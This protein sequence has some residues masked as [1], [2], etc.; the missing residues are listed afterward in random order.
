M[1]ASPDSIWKVL[2]NEPPPTLVDDI[3]ETAG[4]ITIRR[5]RFASG[6]PGSTDAIAHAVIAAPLI[7]HLHPGILVLHGG[8]G[9]A[10]VDRAIAWARRGYVA[11]A[12]DLPGIADA[13]KT[14]YSSGAWRSKPYGGEFWLAEP[15]AS[16]SSI[17]GAV[18]TA[19]RAFRLLQHH[20][21]ADPARLGVIGNSWGGFT[22][23]LLSSLL[24]TEVAAGFSLFGCGSYEETVFAQDLRRITHEHSR[25]WIALL[26][27]LPW[28]S[29]I[30]APFFLAAASNDSFFWPPAVLSTF[31]ALPS[32][33]SLMVA[34]N[35]NHE[36]AFAGGSTSGS[37]FWTA[38]EALFFDLHLRG[39]GLPF[40]RIRVAEDHDGRV[41]LETSGPLPLRDVRLYVS[42]RGEPWATRIW[43]EMPIENCGGGR[44]LA[45][46]RGI[47]ATDWFATATDQRPVS[48]STPVFTW[49]P[50]S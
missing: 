38:Q 3:T 30:R 17:F 7:P 6:W 15:D 1:N 27:P 14:E 26:D 29:R 16:H 21:N 20:S 34:P 10:E 11:I 19:I 40:P 5:V 36:A 28:V 12:P 25:R 50:Q 9:A 35:A 47:A 13:A 33:A 22:S 8:M 45:V 18:A 37:P 32:T 48:C 41:L 4:D 44:F 23:L 42:L 49:T 46:L 24:G 31:H 39:Q 43:K 2:L